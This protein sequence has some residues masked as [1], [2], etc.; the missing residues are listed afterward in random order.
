MGVPAQDPAD[1][2]VL[3]A[4]ADEAFG[5][6]VAAF[7]VI[8]ERASSVSSL[9]PFPTTDARS[10]HSPVLTSSRYQRNEVGA[11]ALVWFAGA[12]AVGEGAFVNRYCSGKSGLS[13]L[14]TDAGSPAP[15][16]SNWIRAPAS[17]G[18]QS[19]K[20]ASSRLRSSLVSSPVCSMNLSPWSANRTS[21]SAAF[22]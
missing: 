10:R 18:S 16:L 4:T 5:Q 3:V 9:L 14:K 13:A 21:P 20:V 11:A 12:A 1:V 6:V 22:V 7:R 15:P 8:G 17:G 19:T 2:I